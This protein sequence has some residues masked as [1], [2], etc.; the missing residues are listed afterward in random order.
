M[1][2]VGPVEECDE[3]FLEPIGPGDLPLASTAA[4]S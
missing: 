4:R 2:G 1:R 3:P